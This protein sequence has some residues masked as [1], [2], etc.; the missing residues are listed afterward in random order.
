M[1]HSIDSRRSRH[2]GRQCTA[3]ALVLL[4]SVGWA[5]QASAGEPVLSLAIDPDAPATVYAGTYCR[6]R[7]HALRLRSC[8][9]R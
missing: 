5:Q 4:A 1:T 6:R 2:T 8:R 7:S 9:G 3:A